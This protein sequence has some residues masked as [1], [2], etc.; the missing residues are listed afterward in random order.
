[1]VGRC[2]AA[3]GDKGGDQFTAANTAAR[4]MKVS[5]DVT[6]AL[7]LA[8]FGETRHRSL[9]DAVVLPPAHEPAVRRPVRDDMDATTA[10]IARELRAL[11]EES[12]GG[13]ER[14]RAKYADPRSAFYS[15]QE[16]TY[17][18]VPQQSETPLR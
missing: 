4:L 6:R 18:P 7:M 12:V 9:S 17:V 5:T 3:M 16:S 10:V 11:A 2:E 8:A 13:W 15:P 14:D 1:M